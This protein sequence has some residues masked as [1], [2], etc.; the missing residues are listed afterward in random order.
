MSDLEKINIF[1]D[2]NNEE[3]NVYAGVEHSDNNEDLPILT[4][5]ESSQELLDYMVLVICRRLQTNNAFKG[6]YM[7]NQLLGEQSR[8]THDIV[9]SISDE[10][11][12]K[13]VKDLLKEIAEQF[14]KVGVISDYRIKETITPTSSGGIDFYDNNGAKILGVNVGLHQLSMGVTHYNFG[15][16]SLQGFTVERMLA[17][18]IMAILSRKRFR[19]TKDLYDFWVITNNFDFDYSN[20]CKMIEIRGNAEWDN[21][22][23]NETVI[24]QYRKAWE[25]LNLVSS[26]TFAELYKPEFCIVIKRFYA[27][28]LPIKAKE[29]FHSWN[30][31][32][33]Y[34]E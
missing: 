21:I 4:G 30:H 26:V 9:F 31:E 27:I 24:T 15:F 20:L 8:M 10:D 29:Q 3:M 18:K 32:K 22:P 7:L 34:L 28:A 1:G 14:H 23:F 12:Y 25:K 13:Y 19:R 11:G 5:N 33:G 2:S 6:G 17:D 16:T